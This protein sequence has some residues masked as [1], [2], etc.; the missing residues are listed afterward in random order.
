MARPLWTVGVTWMA[1]LA[2]AAFLPLNVTVLF[3]ALCALIFVATCFV[4]SLR[5]KWAFPVVFLAAGIAFSLYAAREIL[6]Y[7]PAVRW[8]GQAVQVEAQ[9][10]EMDESGAVDLRVVEDGALPR[11]TGITLY[12]GDQAEYPDLYDRVSGRLTVMAE[13]LSDLRNLG[14][15]AGGFYLTAFPE[16]YGGAAL[17][18]EAMEPPWTAVFQDAGRRAR[19]LIL[20]H[21]P[22]DRGELASLISVGRGELSEEALED[23]RLSGVSH[24]IAVSGLHMVILSQA[25]LSLLKKCRLPSRLASLLAILGVGGYTVLV[26]F[27][28]S[29]VR[30]GILCIVVLL[31]SCVKRRADSLNSMGLA[32]ILLLAADPYAAY[33][34]GLQLSFAACLGLLWLYPFLWEHLR[35]LWVPSVTPGRDIPVIPI[36]RRVFGRLLD[37]ICITLSAMI[38]TLPFTAFWFGSLSLIAPL[39][40]LL[41]VFPASLLLM[42][43]CLG[44]ALHGLPLLTVLT[45][46]L[47]LAA[48]LLSDYLLRVT[49]LLAS[50]PFAAVAVRDGY[51]LLWLPAALGLLILGWRLSR[52]KG[53]RRAAALAAIA[54]F[55]G[56]FARTVSM[57]GVTTLTVAR[58]TASLEVLMER[59]GH[60][61]AVLSGE[62]DGS[63]LEAMLREHGIGTLDFLVV[64]DGRSNQL[65]GLPIILDRYIAD[66]VFL[67]PNGLDSC[68]AIAPEFA[69]AFPLE[70]ATCTFWGGESL[71]WRDGFL[72]MEM[73]NTRLLFCSEEGD[74]SRLP[75][76]WR[77]THLVLYGGVPPLHAG[78]IRASAG[79]MSCSLDALSTALKGIPRTSYPIRIVQQE[80]EDLTLMTRGYG[81][82]TWKVWL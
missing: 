47:F 74:A 21:L 62:S 73:G 46:P 25:V 39:T 11:G 60:A 52:G 12:L 14:Y 33:D 80:T 7:R 22:D 5:R 32:L 82:L 38:P 58:R 3:A 24:I 40:N 57:R 42:A 28:A 81:D 27:R 36:W 77:E 10:V 72:K 70:N 30:A 54:L 48:G 9:V 20:T 63:A 43:A 67:Y 64:T 8:S 15:K 78:A 37:A 26:G 13:D 49:H 69:S 31:G 29:V 76:D 68:E 53:L 18:Y 55:C 34:I 41:T 66:T 56:L 4:S 16:E 71:L 2:I 23:F 45:K 6:V 50:L 35:R 65:T 59:D 75:V 1:V 51:L 79:V 61:G 17:H 44:L 19:D